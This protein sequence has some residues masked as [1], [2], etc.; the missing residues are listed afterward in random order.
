MILNDFKKFIMILKG[1][2]MAQNAS[3]LPRE[4]VQKAQNGTE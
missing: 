3:K 1:H 2:R 4:N